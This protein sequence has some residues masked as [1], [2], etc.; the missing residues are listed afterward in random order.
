MDSN[1]SVTPASPAPP[2]EASTPPAG[3]YPHPEDATREL[4]WDGATWVA[5]TTR[6]LPMAPASDAAAL[7]APD[8]DQ[9]VAP[10]NG[11]ASAGLPGAT[12][13]DAPTYAG[14]TAPPAPAGP[15]ES[16]AKAAAPSF[17]LGAA[18]AI[19]ASL[20]GL[21]VISSRS[22]GILWIGGYLV[23]FFAWRRA[24]AYYKAAAARTGQTLTTPQK[25]ITGVL[26][27]ASLALTGAFAVQYIGQKTA[28]KLTAG[29]GSCWAQ[30]G[31]KAVLVDCTDSTAAFVA[32]GTAATVDQ[33][34]TDSAVEIN[35]VTYCLNRK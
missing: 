24:W 31:D 34:P 13:P 22:G 2:D 23:T 7:P 12:F 26:V 16:P 29:V 8:A 18:V 10:M 5:D 25:A 14:A 28:P 11:S 15:S 20:A 3:W 21:W 32:T 35:N 19:I 17:L 6:P 27:V 30:D 1:E 4:Y 33:C 9:L